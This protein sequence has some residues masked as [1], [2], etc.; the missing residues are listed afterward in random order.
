L[1]TLGA[2]ELAAPN[3]KPP[4]SFPFRLVPAPRSCSIYLNLQFLSLSPVIMAPPSADSFDAAAPGGYFCPSCI[5]EFSSS[6]EDA[7]GVPRSLDLLFLSFF[8]REQYVALYAIFL[9]SRFS[10]SRIFSLLGKV[11][12]ILPYRFSAS[13]YFHRR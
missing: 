5:P 8:E 13:M 12:A 4:V 1:K 6:N 9:I 11:H 3:T 7:E 2:N 10:P